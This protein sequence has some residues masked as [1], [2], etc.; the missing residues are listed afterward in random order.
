M[1]LCGWAGW[2]GRIALRLPEQNPQGECG[3]SKL[4]SFVGGWVGSVQHTYCTDLYLYFYIYMAHLE[5]CAM[6]VRVPLL[7]LGRVEWEAVAFWAHSLLSTVGPPVLPFSTAQGG[8]GGLS[9]GYKPRRSGH[10]EGPALACSESTA[11]APYLSCLA[12]VLPL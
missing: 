5:A 2:L 9:D 11:A 6:Y 12:V 4:P 8:W 1:F 7:R 3:K 10:K